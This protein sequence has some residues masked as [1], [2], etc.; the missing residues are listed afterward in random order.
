MHLF[1]ENGIMFVT[2]P[3]YVAGYHT[4]LLQKSKKKDHDSD[5]ELNLKWTF[6]QHD[7]HAEYSEN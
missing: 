6:V 3:M 2:I 5:H 4:T 7:T 1:L